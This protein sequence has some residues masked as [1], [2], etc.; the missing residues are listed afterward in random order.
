MKLA[1][2][3]LGE[4]GPDFLLGDDAFASMPWIVKPFSQRQLTR[5][6]RIA[7]FRIARGRRVVQNTFEIFV[8]HFR[9]L[10]GKMEQRTKD[11]QT[12]QGGTD[13]APIP[14]NYVAAQQNGQ[15][16]YVPNE[17]YRNPLR[18][19]K[20]QREL[21]KDYLYHVVTLAR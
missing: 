7:N 13:R 18:E 12:H 6:E 16:V 15:V 5:E 8:N 10:L 17:V 3:P 9:V 4:G 19:V 2:E 1:A 11:Y 14:A 21:L 20:H